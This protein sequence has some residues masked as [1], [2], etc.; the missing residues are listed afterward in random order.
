MGNK[1]EAIT[2]YE[3]SKELAGDPNL[4]KFVD[5]KVLELRKN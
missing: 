3:K 2:A 5:G 4:T 1:N